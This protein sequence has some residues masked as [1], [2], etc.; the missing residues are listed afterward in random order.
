VTW[1]GVAPARPGR[2]TVTTLDGSVAIESIA[3]TR[4]VDE[5]VKASVI[6]SASRRLLRYD[7]ARIAGRRVTFFERGRTSYRRIGSVTGGRGTIRLAA[8]GASGPREIVARVDLGGVPSPDRVLARYRVAPAKRLT[9]PTSIRVRRT[10][11]SVSV[12]WGKVNGAK[13]YAVVTRLASGVQRVTRVPGPRTALRLGAI[14]LA[15]TGTVTV[16]ALGQLG[17]WGPARK[18]RFGAPRRAPSPFRPFGELGANGR[19][20]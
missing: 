15:Q 1:I 19:R 11:R 8:S 17:T 2:Y 18:G 7:V 5:H 4:P 10:G 20:R 12:G 6:G 3:A 9:R 13:G 14:P 16:R